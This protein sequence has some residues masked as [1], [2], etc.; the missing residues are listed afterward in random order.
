MVCFRLEFIEKNPLHIRKEV[1]IFLQLIRR[2]HGDGIS[3]ADFVQEQFVEDSVCP[4]LGLHRMI[5]EEQVF[6][7]LEEFFCTLIQF[8]IEAVQQREFALSFQEFVY[9]QTGE[10]SS[11][12]AGAVC[13]T[14]I[15]LRLP[16]V[17][18][19]HGEQLCAVIIFTGH[20][21]NPSNS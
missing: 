8:I 10:E 1:G 6:D 19:C 7:V 14:K 4:S 20:I 12:P 11:L 9:Q 15:N 5:R 17:D 16:A 21:Y 3:A 2:I 18:V 13:G